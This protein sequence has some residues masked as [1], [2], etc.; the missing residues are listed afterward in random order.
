MPPADERISDQARHTAKLAQFEG[1]V[2]VA[3]RDAIPASDGAVETTLHTGAVIIRDPRLTRARLGNTGVRSDSKAMEVLSAE[4]SRHS[5]KA[6]FGSPE[7]ERAASTTR[8]G[9]RAD[10]AGNAGVLP[11]GSWRSAWPR[12]TRIPGWAIA[13][14]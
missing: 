2:T 9:P 3:P 1:T 5:R 12:N 6:L 13:H 7:V 4:M 14:R 11:R 10:G 8:P